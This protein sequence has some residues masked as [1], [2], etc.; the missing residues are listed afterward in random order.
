[1]TAPLD[2]V[3]YVHEPHEGLARLREPLERAGFRPL[4]RFRAPDPEADARAPLL[5]V[6]G[7][8]MGVYDA[9][10]FPFLSAEQEVLRARLAA[11]RPSIGL[12]LGAQLLAAAA[13]STVRRGDRGKVIGVGPVQRIGPADDPVLRALPDSFDVVHWHG[14]TFDPVPGTALFRGETYPAQGFRVG[15][16]V[17]LQFHAELGPEGFQEWIEASAGA[18]RA[19]GRDPATLLSQGIP[20]LRAALPVLDRLLDSL[21]RTARSEAGG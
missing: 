7:G 13:G 2:A 12:C 3:A 9:D 8:P 16:S 1:M 10:R 14:D 21:A 18:L 4:E 19:R 6:L 17:G 5:V 11:G 20:R 15:R